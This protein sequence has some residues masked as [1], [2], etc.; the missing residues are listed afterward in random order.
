MNAAISLCCLVATLSAPVSAAEVY[1]WTDERGV[2]NYG[3]APP[4]KTR[5][6]TWATIVEDRVS[7][8]TPDRATSEAIEH[9]RDA[10]RRAP[11][12]TVSTREGAQARPIL[13]PPPPPPPS[14]APP[15]LAYD[16]C[17]GVGD[18][19]CGAYVYDGAPAIIGR[20]RAA[21]LIQPQLPPGTLAG[22]AAGAG[23]YIPGQ[24]A[25]APQVAESRRS[26][27]PQRG[28]FTTRGAE[29]DHPRR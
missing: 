27:P 23:A 1:R 14:S 12:A 10:R 16:T 20:R 22:Q 28:S 21:P 3:N 29:R 25:N 7:V 4:E 8:Y 6:G 5:A 2:V 26:P 9:N 18:P 13:N 24:S 17:L 19:T 11:A 15:A